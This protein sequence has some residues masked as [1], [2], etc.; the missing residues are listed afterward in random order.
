MAKLIFIAIAI[1]PNDSIVIIDEEIH[2]RC[3]AE[4]QPRCV[5]DSR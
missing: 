3:V 1:E 4:I 5:V 2:P